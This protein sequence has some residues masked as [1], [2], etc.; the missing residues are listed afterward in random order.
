M[1]IIMTGPKDS[2]P[3]FRQIDEFVG[4][5]LGD[6]ARKRY[7]IIIDNPRKV[8]RE[9]LHRLADVK[10]F[11]K[12]HNDAYYFNWRLKIDHEFQKPFSS[13]H[14]DMANTRVSM[15]LPRHE[16]AANL[17]RIF[18]GIVSGNVR[19]DAIQAIEEKGPFEINGSPEIMN[20]LDNLLTSFVD[21]GR[22]KLAAESYRPC[23]RVVRVS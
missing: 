13:S 21:Q 1:P 4:A 20:L 17:R 15:E 9:M 12:Q 23:Y 22:M 11:R 10:A 7:R 19:D 14:E 5:V 6:Q 18:S 3:Y 16:L 8:G 2:E